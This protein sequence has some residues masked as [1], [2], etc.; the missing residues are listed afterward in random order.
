MFHEPGWEAFGRVGGVPGV[1]VGVFVFGVL[2]VGVEFL[3]GLVE[4]SGFFWGDD[5]VY[6]A[7]EEVDGDV[8]EC[9]GGGDDVG[10]GWG[11]AFF[12]ESLEKVGGAWP[13]RQ[14]DLHPER[15]AKEIERFMAAPEMLTEA[16]RNAKSVA[17]PDA[18]KRLADLVE[19][20][21]QNQG[22]RP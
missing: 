12:F 18:V 4:G 11:G 10:V 19:E 22:E 7:V 1:V 21:A 17:K 5:V 3:E 8:F 13:I 2:G 16:A 9:V 20:I 14:A 6:V 15:L